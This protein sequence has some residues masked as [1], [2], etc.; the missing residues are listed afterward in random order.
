MIESMKEIKEREVDK[1]YITTD[2]TYVDDRTH[3]L[4]HYDT[5]GILGRSGDILPMGKEV[6]G[7]YHRDTRYLNKLEM[8][9]NGLWPVLLSSNIKEE[10]DILSVDLTNPEMKVEDQQL[11]HHGSLHIHRSQ[12]VDDGLFYETIELHNH[13]SRPHKIDLSLEFGSDFRDI[14]EVRGMKREKQGDFEGYEYPDDRSILLSYMGLDKIRRKAHIIFRQEISKVESRSNGEVHFLLLL[15]PAEPISLDYSIGF[16]E[17]DDNN[18]KE[19]SGRNNFPV[20]SRLEETRS[21]FPVIETSNEQ[22]THWI[23]RSKADLTSL[24]AETPCGKY[25]Y[26]GVPWYNTAFGR[27]GII[28]ALETLWIAPNLARD[29]LLFLAANQEDQLDEATDAEPGKIL[30][31]TRGGEM[32]ALNEV[33]FKRYY[34]T[35]DATPLFVMLAGEYYHRTSDL[36]TLKKIWPNIIRAIDWINNYGDIDDDGFVEYQHKAINGLTNQGWKDSHDSVFHANGLLADP[37]IALCEVQGYVYSAKI[38]GADLARVFGERDYSETWRKEAQELKE[39]FNDVFWDQ[40]LKS[41]VLALD[42]NKQPC[43]VK[44]SNAGQVLYTG[45]ADVEKAKIMADTLLKPDMFSGWG[46]RTISTQERRYNPMSYHNGSVWPHDVALIADGLARYGY[47]DKALALMTGLFDASLFIHLQRLPELFC[48]MEKRR[49]EGPTAYPVACS[50]QAWSVAAVFILLKAI[51]QI[52]ISP[53]K[54][55][56]SFN[57]PILP[58]Y[59]EYINIKDLMIG[60]D[61]IDLEISRNG[62]RDMVGVNWNYANRGWELRIVK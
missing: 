20:H 23:N 54:S 10:N 51:L 5:F 11:L 47:Q 1:Y 14:F 61:L 4:N 32:V 62:R 28:T 37:P 25:P 49:G 56:I 26:A 34:G 6:Q 41:Y 48:G 9:I 15:N 18:R 39:K 16:G 36:A 55:E 52:D 22:F 42:G 19:K 12:Y 58:K 50:P 43:R 7:L 40:D 17:G 45:I 29:V 35:I 31:E 60:E 53:E 30:H 2:A 24:M 21:F 3:V 13:D 59:L 44:S 8:K 57:K 27:D 46:I 38:H 33:P